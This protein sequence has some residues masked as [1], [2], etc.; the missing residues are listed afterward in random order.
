MSSVTTSITNGLMTPEDES[1]S[2]RTAAYYA[3]FVA[4]GLTGAV[5]GPTLPQLVEGAGAR[6]SV[7][8][9]L[10]AAHSVG[11]LVGSLGGARLFDRMN[12]HTVM[13]GSLLLMAAGLALM[14]LAPTLWLL[15]A[16][17]IALGAAECTLDAGANTLLVATH[18]ARTGPYLNGLHF[19]YG[20]GAFL[21]PLIVAHAAR[22]GEGV[23]LAFWLLALLVLPVAVPFFKLAPPALRAA[24]DDGGREPRRASPALV[25]LLALF[26]FLYLGAEVGFSGWIYTYVV[27]L[28]MSDA[29]GAAY[30]T[31][32]FWG[33]LTLGRLL[34][35]PLAARIGPRVML[36][37]DLAG[38][39]LSIGVIVLSG[40]SFTAVCA[41][42]L[43]LGLSMASIFPA[44]FWLAGR[45]MRLD[46]RTT[47]WLLVGASCGAILV[48]WFAGLV[49]DAAGPRAVMLVV[50]LDLVAAAAIF[51]PLAA[52]S[53][54]KATQ[55]T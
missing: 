5:L 50:L 11:F 47:G 54:G 36:A 27:T 53:G 13:A 20:V 40:G 31:S 14:P 15:A 21:A 34:A 33:A 6:T 24:A 19:F 10:L 30:L 51:A 25:L 9:S 52:R 42:T 29:E 43:G 2:A 23:H 1:R 46:G 35:V 3:A 32:A 16:V 44:T 49:F 39:M 18:G 8:G 38:C 7:T 37:T 26:L 17:L 55:E 28:R 22:P 12:G 45:G 48:P 41:G 4:F